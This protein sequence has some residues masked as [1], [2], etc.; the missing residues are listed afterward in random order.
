MEFRLLYHGPLKPK[1]K[2]S[3]T[4]HKHKLRKQLHPQLRELWRQAPL[5]ELLDELPP[6]AINPPHAYLRQ[7][8]DIGP[9]KQDPHQQHPEA[10]AL[11]RPPS[12]AIRRPTGAVPVSAL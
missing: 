3:D 12:K 1:G 5:K 6:Q 2:K 8:F 11:E 7:S 10:T 9:Y 4:D